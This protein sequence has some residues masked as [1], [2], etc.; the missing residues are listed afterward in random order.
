MNNTELTAVGT[1]LMGY[2]P[3]IT[4][5][6]LETFFGSPIEFVSGK[7]TTEWILN[8]DSEIVTIYDYKNE[9]APAFDESYTW[10]IG[11]NSP[12]AVELVLEILK[13]N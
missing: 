13:G 5:K 1:S 4:R 7:V 11:G 2:T 10:H 3:K 6:E 12:K 9:L 8:L